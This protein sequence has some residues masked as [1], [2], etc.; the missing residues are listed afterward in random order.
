VSLTAEVAL[1][2]EARE[3][4]GYSEPV[5]VEEL[6]EGAIYF[7][8]NFA[9]DRMYYPVL[10]PVV[11]IGRNLREGDVDQVYFQDYDSFHINGIAVLGQS[12]I[13]AD[14]YSGSAAEIGHVFV[15]EKALD[16]ILECSIRRRDNGVF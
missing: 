7:F 4:K 3:L 1:R 15:F 9:D 5:T 14:V 6:Y 11:F 2:F 8:L 16:V 12:H 10:E 13:E